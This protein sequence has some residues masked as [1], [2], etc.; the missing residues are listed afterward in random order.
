MMQPAS[1]KGGRAH[2]VY[3]WNIVD[4]R[5]TPTH[6]VCGHFYHEL[7]DS[8]PIEIQVDGKIVVPVTF[9]C[10]ICGDKRQVYVEKTVD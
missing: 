5:S 1:M 2:Y 9:E 4:R 3:S 7:E 6:C 10:A 8:D